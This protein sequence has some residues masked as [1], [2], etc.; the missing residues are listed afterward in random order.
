M[1]KKNKIYIAFLIVCFS[2]L[3]F[4][5]YNMPKPLDWS[6]TFS[7]KDKIPYGT[8]ALYKLLPDIFPGADISVSNKPAYNIINE[9]SY[10]GKSLILLSYYFNPDTLDTKSLLQ[11]VEE[12]NDAFIAS[13]YFLG[14][15]ADTL[16]LE[17]NFQF[18]PTLNKDSDTIVSGF[19]FFSSDTVRI[20]FANSNLKSPADYVF[21]K[22]V[23]NMC[24]SSFDSSRSHIISIN[25]SEKPNLIRI[26]F[27]KGNFYL[28]TLPQVFS[29]YC[30]VDEKN[31]EYAYKALS[32][33]PLQDIIWDE[34]YKYGNNKSESP[35]RFVFNNP[36]LL[37]A[38]YTLMAGLILFILFGGKRKQR[39][40]PV[41]EPL[42]NTTLEF[43][44]IVGTLYFQQGDHK[45]I[46][47]K[48]ISYFLDYIRTKFHLKTNQ[49][50]SEFIKRVSA[51][52]GI[53]EENVWQTF[54]IISVATNSQ[55]LS[56]ESLLKL[57]SAIETFYKNSKR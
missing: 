48:K 36:P 52:S 33:L 57:N 6:P 50:D 3:I 14:K 13:S 32:Y 23:D 31:C 27:G 28:S 51:L 2:A 1:L 39:I 12:G 47:D 18:F 21:P 56:Q 30:F 16:N 5:Q 11:F 20:N 45:N 17:T 25:E 40:I 44:D 7:Q 43:V 8:Y 15:F 34:Y 4:I 38:Y 41:I 49:I 37:A 35:L 54:N 53:E 26:V 29:N 22:A 46:A 10:S 24:F 42:K 55:S 19:Q 9:D